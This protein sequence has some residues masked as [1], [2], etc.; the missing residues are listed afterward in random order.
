MRGG[1][2]SMREGNSQRTISDRKRRVGQPWE[3]KGLG[4]GNTTEEKMG[5]RMV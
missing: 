4:K 1:R 3:G 5:R 2:E